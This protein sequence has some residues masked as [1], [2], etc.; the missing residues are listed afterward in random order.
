MLGYFHKDGIKV[1]AEVLRRQE[2]ITGKA[3]L[4]YASRGVVELS[5]GTV[6]T[7]GVLHNEDE[8]GHLSVV[9]DPLKHMT[10]ER[11]VEIGRQDEAQWITEELQEYVR[12]LNINPLMTDR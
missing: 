9:G 6:R 8:H 10:Y 2:W 1:T 11:A 7:F 12:D 5:D 4:Q 3:K